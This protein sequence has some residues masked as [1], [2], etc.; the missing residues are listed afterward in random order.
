MH[1]DFIGVQT[2]RPSVCHEN[3]DDTTYDYLL[4]T[5]ADFPYIK[6]HFLGPFHIS[7]FSTTVQG[8][9]PFEVSTVSFFLLPGQVSGAGIRATSEEGWGWGMDCLHL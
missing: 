9:I 8:L 3:R 4:S 7:Q 1:E 5:A 2:F 6:L